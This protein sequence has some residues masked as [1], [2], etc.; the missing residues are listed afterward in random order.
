M[1]KIEFILTLN[2]VWPD[3][4]GLGQ[5]HNSEEVNRMSKE[6]IQLMFEEYI[7][8]CSKRQ[9]NSE[10]KQILIAYIEMRKYEEMPIATRHDIYR[11]AQEQLLGELLFLKE[12]EYFVHRLNEIIQAG[13]FSR[14]TSHTSSVLQLIHDYLNHAEDD[15]S[16]DHKLTHLKVKY[17]DSSSTSN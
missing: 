16:I 10:D 12:D 6:C 5:H 4:L 8:H 7:Q 17:E 1:D 3:K 15:K 9:L 13:V 2:E 14:R 11:A